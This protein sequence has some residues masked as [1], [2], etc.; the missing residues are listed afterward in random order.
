MKILSWRLLFSICI[1]ISD[2]KLFL[3]L[4]LIFV[5]VIIFSLGYQYQRQFNLLTPSYLIFSIWIG[6]G[7]HQ[8]ENYLFTR[9]N[10]IAFLSLAL[11]VLITMPLALYYSIPSVLNKYNYMPIKI[12]NIPY[13]DS[14]KYFLLP[15]KSDHYEAFYFGNEVFRLVDNETLLIVIQKKFYV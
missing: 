5:S 12:R 13:R 1:R 14:I 15:D 3:L 4:I 7:F 8:F 9:K 2:S 10:K 6:I 11:S